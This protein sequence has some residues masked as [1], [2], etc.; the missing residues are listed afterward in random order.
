MLGPNAP[1]SSARALT[2]PLPMNPCFEDGNVDSIQGP[3]ATHTTSLPYP[4]RA[5]GVINR[6]VERKRYYAVICGREVGVFENW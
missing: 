4:C 3:L 6:P 2:P 1:L 5:C